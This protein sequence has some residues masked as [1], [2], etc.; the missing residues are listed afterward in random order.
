MLFVEFLYAQFFTTPPIPNASLSGQT[1]IITGS[2]RGLGF[3]AAK[4][5]ARLGVS[6]LILAVRSTTAGEEAKKAILKANPSQETEI[7]VWT[8]DLTN[9]NSVKAFARRAETLPRID[10]LVNNAGI[11]TS[12][13]TI[14]EDNEST[15]TVN[16]ISTF[17]L[18]TLMLP[19]LRESAEKFDII[20]RI[21][22]LGS[23]GQ[24][25]VQF[26]ERKAK[27]GAIFD[28]LN[29]K[30]GAIMKER[31]FVS[32]LLVLFGVRELA[33]RM[34]GSTNNRSKDRHVIINCIAPGFCATDLT[35]EEDDNIMFKIMQKIL[36]RDVEVGSRCVVDGVA[37]G[38][39]SHGQYLSEC[40]VK[41]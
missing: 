15:I 11:A 1:V 8:L 5:I 41:S 13:F 9:Y 16:V 30:T 6:K 12:I 31:Y 38:Q 3:E 29:S 21:S 40:K 39:E 32:K 28:A 26:K 4:H 18:S 20:P 27:N 7:E 25:W 36:A 22:I 23:E 34:S 19:K 37:R 33:A 2:N 24:N 10:A 35:H 17:L 14:A